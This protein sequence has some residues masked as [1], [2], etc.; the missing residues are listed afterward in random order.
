MVSQVVEGSVGRPEPL[1]EPAQALA[2]RGV[3]E[4]AQRVAIRLAMHGQARIFI[5]CVPGG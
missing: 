5:D 2:R 1:D 3:Q 4:L